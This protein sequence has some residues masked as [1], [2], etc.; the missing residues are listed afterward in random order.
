[1][2]KYPQ[3]DSVNF[4]Y[5]QIVTYGM[6]DRVGPVSF[7]LKKNTDFAKKPYSDKLARMID[8]VIIMTIS[9][10]FTF[11]AVNVKNYN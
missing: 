7:H 10:N 8:E 1:M 5:F 9:L 2:S 4:G 3:I 11:S 6:N